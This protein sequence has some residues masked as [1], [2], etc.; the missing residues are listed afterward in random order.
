MAN[1]VNGMVN[2]HGPSPEPSSLTL[3]FSDVPSTIEIPVS[4]GAV[5]EAVE[6][7][8][9]DLQDDPTELC[10]LLEN[11]NVGRPYWITIALAYAK[12]DNIDTA[13]EIINRGIAAH[14]RGRTD[15]RLALYDCLCWFYLV[16]SRAA[17]R[18]LGGK[19]LDANGL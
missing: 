5:D 8:V 4:G 3:R 7:E 17:P 9:D 1:Q 12:K 19:R 16:K 6:L 11:E 10:T 2:G 14:S 13:I 15:D 18:V